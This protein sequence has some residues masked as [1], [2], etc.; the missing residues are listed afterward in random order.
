MS[1]YAKTLLIDIDGTLC[2][3]E[4]PEL[5]THP[6]HVMELLPGSA[7]RL[8]KWHEAGHLI[9]LATGRAES[10]REATVK[11][12]E[13]AGLVYDQLVMGLTRGKRILINDCKPDGT[14]TVAA[15]ALPRNGGIAHVNE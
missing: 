7:D 6:D 3:H 8:R 10:K 9:I 14:V 4:P 5:A 11:Q 2:V 15:Y 12:L 13:Q 1:D